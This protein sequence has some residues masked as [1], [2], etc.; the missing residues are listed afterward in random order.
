MHK[1]WARRLGSVFRTILLYSLADD[2]LDGWNGRPSSLWDFYSKDVNLNGKV[3]LDP[4]M[5]GGTTV[6][7]ALKLGC[8]VIAGDLNPVSWFLVKKQVEDIN[9]ELLVHNLQKLDDDLG[10][11]LRQYYQTI[12]PECE[13]T[14]E[15]IY[16]FYHKVTS[17][18]K[19]AK[20]THLM[21]N[22]FLARSPAGTGDI[23]VCPQCWN[24]F[25]SKNAKNSTT[26]SKCHE[27]F[28]PTEVSF[29]K[30]R[31]FTCSDCGHSEKIVEVTRASGR[32]QERMYAIEFYCKHCDESKN[33]KLVNGRGYK[34]SDE[35]DRELL[36][37]AYGEYQSIAESLPIPETLIPSGVETK[38]A[39]NHGY[40]KFS[41]MFSPRQLLNLGK[42]YR[43][44]LGIDDWNLKEFFLLAFS[45]SLKY[46]NM[47]AKYNSTRGFITDIFRTHSFSPSMSPVEANCYDTAKGRGAFTAF[48]NLVIEGKEYCR[49]PF[50]RIHDGKSMKKVKLKPKDSL[51]V[52]ENY[53]NLVK[54]ADV[55]LRCGSS[56]HLEIPDGVVDAVVTDPPYY[57]NVMYSELSNFFYVWLRIALKDRY[58]IFKDQ[59]VPTDEE[60]IENRHQGKGKDEFI[61]G[62][63]KVFTEANRVLSSDGILVFT[64]H[65][66][67]QD[68]WGAILRTILDS[69]FYV[70][71]TYPVRSEMKASTH[72]HELENIVYDM[73][74]VCRKRRE[75]TAPKSWKSIISSIEHSVTK[76]IAGLQ[77]N[78]ETPSSVDTFA[79]VL[80]KCLELYSKHYPVVMDGDKVVDPETALESI[81]KLLGG[82]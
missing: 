51:R 48:V 82:L 58:E 20:E 8:K 29:S 73:I 14:A 25:E 41:D 45:N 55:M 64:F 3:V 34:T 67:K 78:G 54:N 18:S 4:M 16:Y 59:L 27:K 50:E 12:C 32:F 33:R 17:C 74:F 66:K 11:E 13:E 23:V 52:T 53:P 49:H 62:L 19:C 63:T 44:I 72:L 5:G 81:E 35:R 6:T 2:D 39:L 7:E 31:K 61:H 28:T 9:P 30:G 36:E 38:R 47:F 80:G 70:T 40:R 56:E 46:N 22:F 21:R 69:G 68:A 76:T 26:C 57:G 75:E 37:K 42:I 15:A 43:W 24:V 71:T 65:H 79:M 1:W 77:T 10:A 60:V